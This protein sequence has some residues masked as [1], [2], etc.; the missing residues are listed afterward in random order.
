MDDDP[1]TVLLKFA[2]IA[3]LY[4]FLLWVARSA[5]KDLG[6]G[7]AGNAQ[8]AQA[9]SR[10]ADRLPGLPSLVVQG[11]GGLR[12]G[13]SF[14]INGSIMIGR[15]PQTDVPIEDS[16]AS[17]R[18]ARLFERDGLYYVEDLGST[19]GTY[20]NGRR[21]RSQQQLSGEDVIRIGDTEFRYRQ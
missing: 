1:I 9:Q 8:A 14:A 3:V 16:F 11:G 12:A 13:S 6:R 5:L 21:L 15:S 19:N 10:P 18:H 20:L 4:L 17:A 2:F 7:V